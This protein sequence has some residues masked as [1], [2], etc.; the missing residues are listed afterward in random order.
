MSNKYRSITVTKLFSFLILAL[1]LIAC[2]KRSIQQYQSRSTANFN[3]IQ[4][5]SCLLG[6]KILFYEDSLATDGEIIKVPVWRQDNFNVLDSLHISDVERL[7]SNYEIEFYENNEVVIQT[8]KL[9]LDAKIFTRL[10]KF[11][12]MGY[13]I[14]DTT[15]YNYRLF[16]LKVDS[17]IKIITLNPPTVATPANQIRSKDFTA[18]TLILGENFELIKEVIEPNRGLFCGFT[19]AKVKAKDTLLLNFQVVEVCYGCYDDFWWY[20]VMINSE[21]EFLDAFISDRNIETRS[22]YAPSDSLLKA[23]EMLIWN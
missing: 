11:N 3:P 15:F 13:Q 19:G 5:D 14:N 20:N 7:Y 2:E 8:K 6:E 18:K 23:Q 17:K 4:S 10:I 21:G 16:E 12:Q 1:T 9:Y 22:R